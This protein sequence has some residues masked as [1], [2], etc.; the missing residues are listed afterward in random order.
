MEK[1]ISELTQ[2]LAAAEAELAQRQQAEASM[3]LETELA[4]AWEGDLPSGDRLDY[5]KF[6]ASKRFEH[7]PKRGALADKLGNCR[8]MKDFRSELESTNDVFKRSDD[9]KGGGAVRY[10][11]QHQFS[12]ELPKDP[13]MKSDFLAGKIAVRD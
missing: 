13:K 9:V 11:T 5:L 1:S 12:H 6:L 2:K 8:D 10:I 3:R 7:D 4:K